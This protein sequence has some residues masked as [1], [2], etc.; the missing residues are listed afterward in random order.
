MEIL[1]NQQSF[2]VKDMPKICI[3]IDD[4]VGM[5]NRTAQLNH[6]LSRYRHYNC[7]VI[8]SVQS[9]KG[10]SPIGRANATDVILMNGICNTKEWEKISDEYDAQYKGQLKRLYDEATEKPYNFLYLKMRAN[11]AEAYHNFQ[12]LIYNGKTEKKKKSRFV[13]CEP[14]EDLSSSDEEK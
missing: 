12:K 8:I 11:P 5:I 4:S 9:F 13:K 2:S 10:I 6:F 14:E 3:V 1:K 7:N